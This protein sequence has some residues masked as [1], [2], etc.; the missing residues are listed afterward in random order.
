MRSLVTHPSDPARVG[1]FLISGL[2][3]PKWTEFRAAVAFVKRSGTQFIAPYLSNFAKRPGSVVNISIGVNFGG[4]SL[5]GVKQLV[6]AVAG[7]GKLWVY[8][9]ASNTFHPKVFLFRNATT[10]DFVV[11]SGNLTKGGLFEN[12]EAF[13]RNVLDLTDAVD[14][15]LFTSVEAMLDRWAISTPNVCLPLDHSVL[16]LLHASGDLP[17]EAEARAAVKRALSTIKTGT[18]KAKSL[19]KSIGFPK[20][21]SPPPSLPTST[22][23]IS[24][25]AAVASSSAA[26]ISKGP[27]F[28]MTL[29]N[30][31]VGVG[32]K[33]KG[34]QRRSP[35]VF[36]P[37]QALDQLPSFWNWKSRFIPSSTYKRDSK[38][39]TLPKN[40]AWIKKESA[41]KKRI[42]RPLD[43]LDWPQVK[44]RLVGHPTLLTATIWFNP[45]K[46]D[47]RIRED[48]IR[49][50]GSIGDILLVRRPPAGAGYDFDIEIAMTAS[51][52]FG[53]TLGKL[54]TKI[55]GSKKAIGYF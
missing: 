42:P 20:A 54:T 13:V 5:E 38:W 14:A 12:S 32:Q 30:T 34:K 26:V 40:A 31:D 1:D 21:P 46:K 8:R 33:S 25:P 6:D 37:L 41:R 4:S 10:A 16:S 9:N 44:I 49:S 3:D 53:S 27:T 52:T 2:Q 29:Q 17:T 39:R 36:I 18:K 50:A 7:M 23:P 35:E 51:P 24:L 11:G 47:L 43:K 45:I 22:T 55:R 15:A 48:T 28:G 19:F